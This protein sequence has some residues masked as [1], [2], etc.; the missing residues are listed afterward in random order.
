VSAYLKA[1]A[2]AL[3]ATPDKVAIPLTSIGRKNSSQ[4][5]AAPAPA[6]PVTEKP[7]DSQTQAAPEASSAPAGSSDVSAAAPADSAT[8]TAPVSETTET[9][10]PADDQQAAQQPEGDKPTGGRARERI[11]DLSAQLKA[12]KEYADYLQQANQQ[13]MQQ[14]QA[15]APAAPTQPALAAAAPATDDPAPTLEQCEFDQAKWT[16]A[17]AEWTRRQIKTGVTAELQGAQAE[18]Q[19]QAANQAFNTRLATFKKS[20][21]DFDVLAGNPNLPALHPDA[22]ALTIASEK[23]P[24]I[25]YHFLKNPGQLAHIARMSPTQQGAAIGK[26]EAQLTAPAAAP[27]TTQKTVS[28]TQAPAPPSVTPGSSPG[29]SRD[30]ARMSMDEF[31][32]HRRQEAAEK[33]ARRDKR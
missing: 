7:A 4:Q 26:L 28:T 21:P 15:T 33:R 16:K 20:A 2:Q 27:R 29:P 23:G 18:Q 9:P 3:L 30:P 11:E 1:K 25:V 31:V 24:Q 10:A 5:P 12:T 6:A 22:A 8:A 17:H 32:A 14:R 13:L 19:R